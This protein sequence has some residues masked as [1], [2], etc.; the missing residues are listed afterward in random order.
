[1]RT[2]LVVD[3]MAI[4]REP[5]AQALEANGYRAICASS[6]RDALSALR[7][8]AIDMMLLDITMPEM[9]GLDVL[10]AVRADPALRNL[11]V[12]LLT[13]AAERQSVLQARDLG[14]RHYLLKSEFTLDNMFSR[15]EQLFSEVQQQTN[16]QAGGEADGSAGGESAAA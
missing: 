9:S 16:P 12:V 13:A 3:D 15:V 4:F 1:M 6:G 7:G 11:P 5:I 10:R 14:V 2:I 8:G